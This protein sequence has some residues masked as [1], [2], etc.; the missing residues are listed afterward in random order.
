MQAEYSRRYG[1]DGD[2]SPIDLHEFDPPGGVF[3]MIYV[4]GV[5]A[6]M[7]GWR[8]GKLGADTAEVKR[9]YVRPQFARRG[10]ARLILAE[11][12]RSASDAGFARLVL[13][14]GT[15]QPEAI[16]LYASSGFVDIPAFGFYAEYDDSVHMGKV[17]D[18]SEASRPP[19]GHVASPS[20]DS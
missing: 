12:E 17:L 3:Y 1:G 2:I 6:A 16:S 10:L 14:T 8:R 15:A 11:L 4:G 20:V 5:P 7:G 13:E 18:D 19:A 9:M